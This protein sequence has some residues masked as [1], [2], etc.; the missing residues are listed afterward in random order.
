MV[1]MRKIFIFVAILALV[2]VGCS[3]NKTS[4]GGPSETKLIKV[5]HYA[6]ASHPLSI[7]LEEKFKKM[8]EEN[9]NGSLKV[10]VYGDGKLGSEAEYFS[11]LRAGNIQMA[12]NGAIMT[13]EVPQVDVVGLPFLFDDIEHAKKVLT[14]DVAM[15]IVPGFEEKLG[16]HVLGFSASGFRV[17]TNNSP[18]E[19]LADFKGMKLRT[20]EGYEV[21]TKT[22]QALQANVTP[23]PL[24]EL[25][26]S[27]EQ[28]V[29]DGQE[30]PLSTIISARIY[31]VQDYVILTRH[32]LA[33]DI[34]TINNKFW[35]GLTAEEQSIIEDAIDATVNNV[36]TLLS[37]NETKH[38]EYLKEQGL[39]VTEI[40]PEFRQDLRET[41]QPVYDWYYGKNPWAKELVEKISST[42]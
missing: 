32:I 27:I 22:G 21:A 16:L 7:S 26:T 4:T 25:F 28:G 6:G 38:I 8:V 31:E 2:L 1:K 42:K 30:N 5:A 18:I 29:I 20:S 41:V 34:I 36:W 37:E 40:S 10:E 9:S 19:S 3:S 23:L 39:E 17:F 11:V 15:E 12:V 24:T 13:K 14:S 33:H 35:E